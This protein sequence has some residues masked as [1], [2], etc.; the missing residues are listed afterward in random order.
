MSQNEQN[1][2]DSLQILADENNHMKMKL[3]ELLKEQ[4]DLKFLLDE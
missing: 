1:H 3:Q 4:A 2:I